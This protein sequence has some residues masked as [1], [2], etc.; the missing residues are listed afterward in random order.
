M[1]I[2]YYIQHCLIL[3]QLYDNLFCEGKFWMG[4]KTETRLLNMKSGETETRLDCKNI[5][6]P[7]PRLMINFQRKRDRDRDW[8][9]FKISHETETRPRVLYTSV[10]RPRRD[11]D[12][13]QSVSK[14][15]VVQGI[16]V[17]WIVVQGI[18]VQGTISKW[19][20][21]TGTHLSREDC[22]PRTQSEI[23]TLWKP[24]L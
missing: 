15:M 8:T 24:Q 4:D 17:Q 14:D 2:I 1:Y 12:S 23:S 16:V 3:S 9:W 11:W 7:R 19:D 6:R 20:R 22:C 13:S 21:S 18:V 10:S 5:S